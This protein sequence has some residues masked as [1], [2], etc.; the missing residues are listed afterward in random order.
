MRRPWTTTVGTVALVLALGS[1]AVAQE[2]EPRPD[3]H[4][5]AVLRLV[6]DR[7]RLAELDG[8]PA[9]TDEA[10]IA[11]TRSGR[12]SGWTGCNELEGTWTWLTDDGI[13]IGDLQLTREPCDEAATALEAR[14]V[15]GLYRAT[16]FAVAGERMVLRDGEGRELVFRAAGRSGDGVLGDWVLTAIDGEPAA[17]VPRSTLTMRDDGSLSGSGGCND[18]HAW[19][20]VDDGTIEVSP[21]SAGRG[22]CAEHA[23]TQE[24]AFLDTLRAASGWAVDGDELQ[25]LTWRRAMVLRRVLPVNHDL[26][27]TTWTITGISGPDATAA[28]GATIRFA[29]DGTLSGWS[30]CNRYRAPWHIEQDSL[31]MRIGPVMT[32]RTRCDEGTMAL[33]RAYLRTLEAVTGYKVPDGASLLLIGAS[34]VRIT[35]DPPVVPTLTGV[36]WH[37]TAVGDTPF[38]ALAPVN[39]RFD[40]D[41]SIFGNGG[42][43]LFTATFEQRGDTLRIWDVSS[44]DR[45]CEQAVSDFEESFLG[46]LPAVSGLRFDGADLLLAVADQHIRFETR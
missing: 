36:T 1:T 7:W 44:G 9:A 22:T 35:Y 42:C 34:D 18:Y 8:A 40:D 12:V 31:V 41:G 23:M 16:T 37:L 28:A 24:D 29:D 21:I 15:E 45:R 39:I 14:L 6:T 19:F 20:T 4:R 30:G 17:D 33:E 46:L 3:P 25:L 32:G 38:A 2:A 43:D 10:T 11:F 13:S 26:V 5:E 27:D